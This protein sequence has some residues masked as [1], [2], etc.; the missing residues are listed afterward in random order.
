LVLENTHNRCNGAPLDPDYMAAASRLAKRYGLSLHVDGARIFNAAVSLKASVK[1][2]VA[3]ADSVS[4]CLSK[5]LSAPVGSLVCGSADFIARARRMRKVLGG[6]MRQAG[7][8]AAAGI[9]AVT[10]MVERLEEDHQNARVLA[11]GIAGIHGIIVNPDDIRTNIVFFDIDPVRIMPAEQ[12]VRELEQNGVRIIQ[13]GA[14]RL[15][16]VTNRMVGRNDIEE[17]VKTITQVVAS[18]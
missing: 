1:E 7:V 11:E 18:S 17:A 12:F 15:R 9:I 6:G 16:A 2:L 8:L 14:N 4:F 3:G 10:R 5:G 13:L